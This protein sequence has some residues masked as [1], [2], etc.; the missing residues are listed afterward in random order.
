MDP[1][2][3][4]QAGFEKKVNPSH[5]SLVQAIPPCKYSALFI[6]NTRSNRSNTLAMKKIIQTDDAPQAIGPYSQAVQAGNTLYV[7]G[8]IPVD[9]AT[10]NVVEGDIN[11]QTEQ[12]MNNIG[13]VLEAAGF[14]YADVVKSTCLLADMADFP[15]FNE[16][17]GA[18]YSVEPP[19]RATF[20]VKGLPLGVLV[21][22]DAVAVKTDA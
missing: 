6:A 5:T 11:E 12:V 1:G 10:G 9:P 18:C 16:I 21:E 13:A 2:K 4:A 7:S 15:T 19:A 22:V 17:Y 3:H 20:A 14:T 8:Q